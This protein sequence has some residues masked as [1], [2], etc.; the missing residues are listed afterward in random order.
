MTVLEASNKL[1]KYFQSATVLAQR[2]NGED[3]IS[4]AL[5]TISD[6]PEQERAAALCALRDFEKADIVSKQDCAQDN[7][8]YWVLKRPFDSLSQSVDIEPGLA[9][10]IGDFINQFCESTKDQTD[11]CDVTN[12]TQK[13]LKNLYLIGIHLASKL[14]SFLPDA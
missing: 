2:A 1:F 3:D 7:V 13:D 10:A 8:T 14:K 5:L 9:V 4:K 6:K 12:I 11:I